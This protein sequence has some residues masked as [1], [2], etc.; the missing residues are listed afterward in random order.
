MQ[1]YDGNMQASIQVTKLTGYCKINVLLMIKVGCY[2]QK[3][4]DCT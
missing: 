1:K 4:L 3:G 2:K